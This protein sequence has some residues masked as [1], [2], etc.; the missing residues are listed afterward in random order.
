MS[1]NL[2]NYDLPGSCT[3]KLI[4]TFTEVRLLH[5]LRALAIY[6]EYR[7]WKKEVYNLLVRQ[8]TMD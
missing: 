4:Y 8:A 7:I 2:K 1:Q 3:L 6:L 5:Q